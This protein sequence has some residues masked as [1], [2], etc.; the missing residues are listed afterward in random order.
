MN[1]PV[2]ITRMQ[3]KS[4]SKGIIKLEDLIRQNPHVDPLPEGWFVIEFSDKVRDE[5]LI[6][7]KWVGEDVVLFRDAT[8]GKV[9]VTQAYCPHMGGHFDAYKKGGCVKD[10]VITCPYHHLEF[11]PG[12]EADIA[13][14][15]G[16]PK[17]R[18]FETFEEKGFV[19]ALRKR[20]PDGPDI[21]RPDLSFEVE[22]ESEYCFGTETFGQFEGDSL[23]PYIAN[24]DVEHFR[25]V[26]GFPYSESEQKFEVSD[27]GMIC[28]W[29]FEHRDRRHEEADLKPVMGGPGGWFRFFRLR[30]WKKQIAP[31]GEMPVAKIRTKSWGVG[32]GVLKSD[33]WEENWGLHLLSLLYI[34]PI[35]AFSYEVFANCGV[36]TIRRHRNRTVQRILNRLGMYYHLWANVKVGKY[37]DLPFYTSGKIRLGRPRYTNFDVLTKSFAEWWKHQFFSKEY[38]EMIEGYDLDFRRAGA[39]PPV[40]PRA[41]WLRAARGG[42]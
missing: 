20:D 22:D 30:G 23:V 31:P 24:A 16:R 21:P 3:R 27:D 37:D 2:S 11:N 39:E 40:D 6:S 18:V 41:R 7:K 14:A 10:G 15:G 38:L 33:W 1:A 19:F 8:T 35:D 5:K 42:R 28:A 12:K 34:T 36:R 9:V 32:P 25:T 29:V 17:L 4:D 13:R 26:H